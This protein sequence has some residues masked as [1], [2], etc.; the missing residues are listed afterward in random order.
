MF[1]DLQLV[2]LPSGQGSHERYDGCA[3][4]KTFSVVCIRYSVPMPAGMEPGPDATKDGGKP[5]LHL[6]KVWQ[7][8]CPWTCYAS[9]PTSTAQLLVQGHNCL[10]LTYWCNLLC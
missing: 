2:V 10:F 7:S 5:R 1:A 4:T 3:L 8:H 6:L 9:A